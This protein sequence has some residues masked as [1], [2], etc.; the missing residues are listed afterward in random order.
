MLS[1]HP[2]TETKMTHSAQS[3]TRFTRFSH[4]AL[5]WLPVLATLAMAAAPGTA[6]AAGRLGAYNGT[7]TTVFATRAAIALPATAFPSPSTATGFPRPVAAGSPARSTAAARLRSRCRSAPPGRA[8]AAGSPATVARAHGAASLPATAAAAPGR[9]REASAGA[10][11]RPH[12]TL[13][14]VVFVIFVRALWP[15]PAAINL[16]N[17]NGPP[18]I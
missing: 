4:H 17:E 18:E 7:W 9:R 13:H 15:G 10:R 16:R 11:L 2:G 3:I 1:A 6:D 12:S 5:R 14:G 8:A